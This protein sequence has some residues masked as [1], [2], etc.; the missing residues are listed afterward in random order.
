MRQI[1]QIIKR[2]FHSYCQQIMMEHP[3]LE[4]ALAQII[5]A[6]ADAERKALLGQS[7]GGAAGNGSSAS[8]SVLRSV[9]SN[10]AARNSFSK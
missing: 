5:E 9:T 4:S 7:G 10:V 8:K 6:E 1:E 2:V 3:L